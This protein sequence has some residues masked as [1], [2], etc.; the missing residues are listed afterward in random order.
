MVGAVGVAGQGRPWRISADIGG[1]RWARGRERAGMSRKNDPDERERKYLRVL[2]CAATEFA[3]YG[4]ERANINT[5][6][7]HAG[8]GK[9]TIYLYAQSKEELFANVLSETGAQVREALALHLHASEGAPAQ[10]RLR[11]VTTAFASLARTHPDFVRVQLSALFGVNPRFQALALDLLRE[12]SGLVAAQLADAERAG[13]M[14]PAPPEGLAALL[15]SAL[16]L[17]TLPPQTLGDGIT[18]EQ[19]LT[20]MLVDML[21]HGLAPPVGARQ[22]ATSPVTTAPGVWD[23]DSTASVPA[24]SEDG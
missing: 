24:L 22:P 3:T 20:E 10:A 18:D 5:I 21:W 6:A 11:A 23:D 8:L 17:L 1:F 14:R 12:V 2:E 4:F 19:A 13:L 16:Q 9:G 15:V 7:E